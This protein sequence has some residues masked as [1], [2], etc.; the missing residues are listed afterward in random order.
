MSYKVAR[1]TLK[2][3]PPDEFMAIHSCLK[4]PIDMT[5]VQARAYYRKSVM[6]YGLGCALQAKAMAAGWDDEFCDAIHSGSDRLSLTTLSWLHP[7]APIPMQIETARVLATLPAGIAQTISPEINHITED[8][9]DIVTVTENAEAEI[10]DYQAFVALGQSIEPLLFERGLSIKEAEM[11][12]LG[13][14]LGG[15]AL[16]R[17]LS[18]QEVDDLEALFQL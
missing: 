9:G 4:A 7:E 5:T 2:L 3:I 8:N 12:R 18:K 15:L 14:A 10:D 17:H 6:L 1:E 11:E 13:T 16:K